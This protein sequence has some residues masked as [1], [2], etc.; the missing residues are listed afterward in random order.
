MRLETN[1]MIRNQMRASFLVVM[2]RSLD[3]DLALKEE[4][5]KEITKNGLRRVYL[6]WPVKA[7]LP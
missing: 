4:N 1:C 7:E 6:K 2:S 5:K 3:I